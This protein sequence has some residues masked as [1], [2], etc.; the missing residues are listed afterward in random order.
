MIKAEEILICLDGSSQAEKIVPLA[1]AIAAANHTTLSV[2]R[3][4]QDAAEL[5]GEEDYLRDIA[6]PLGAQIKFAVSN[7]PAQ[8]IIEELTKSP[9]ALAAMT[10][11]GRTA[12]GEAILGSVAFRVLR[13]SARPIVLWRPLASS[14]DAPSKIATLA[15][16]LDGSEFAEKIIASAASMAKSLAAGVTLIQALPIQSPAPPVPEQRKTDL[17]ESSYL[18]RQASKIKKTYGL[19]AQ[20]DVLHGDAAGAICRYVAGMP[21]TMLAMTSHGRGTLQRVVLGSVAG[22]C[23]RHA[24]C[25]LLLYWPHQ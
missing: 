3:V 4:V 20:W 21:N 11:H 9:G 17:M 22:E 13:G 15:V 5:P 7:D 6:R 8:A 25:P 2:F 16:A 19:D 10:T 1:R 24:G 14:G 23:I 12:W 18:H